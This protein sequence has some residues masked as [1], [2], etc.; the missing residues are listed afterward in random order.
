MSYTL[1]LIIH[2]LCAIIFIGFVFADVIVL[3]AMKK[4]LNEKE[5][6]NVV[7]AISGRAR[8]IFPLAVL[9]LI[10]TGGFMFSKYINSDAGMFNSSLQILLLIKFVLAMI[11]T[12]GIVYSL[13]C[14]F[15]KKAP[16]PIMKHFHKFVLVVGVCI[17]V[18]AKLMFV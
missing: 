7:N 8:K 11:I 6:Q 15:L 1:V 16:N 5:H 13:S 3:P 10:L 12:G 4:V 17:V 2:L 14:K 18:L 9:T